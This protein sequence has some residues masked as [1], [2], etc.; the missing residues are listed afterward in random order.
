MGSAGS[1]ASVALVGRVGGRCEL[2][3]GLAGVGAAREGLDGGHAPARERD[4]DGEEVV[5][6]GE[7]GVRVG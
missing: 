4:G 1:R 2:D 3:H 6:K 7:G 5:V